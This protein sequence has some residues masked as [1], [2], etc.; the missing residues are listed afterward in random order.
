MDDQQPKIYLLPNLMTAGNL[1]CGFFAINKIILGGLHPEQ[2]VHNYKL[3]LLL[4]I[5]AFVFDFLDGR[6]ARMGGFESPFGIQFDSLADLVSFGLAPALL[7]V[8]IVLKDFGPVSW[9]IAFVYLVCG[10]LRLARFNCLAMQGHK[11]PTTDFVGFPIP[12]AAGV[13]A[14]L[15]LFMMWLNDSEKD[16]GRW[17][18]ALPALTLFLSYM[19]FSKFKYPSF[20]TIDWKTQF[21]LTKLLIV[22]VLL[23]L[24]GFFH[25]VMLAV[26]FLGYLLYGFFRPFISPRIRQEIEEGDDNEGS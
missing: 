2:A 22:I 10:A 15:T 4:I 12:A 8:N 21:S 3:S 14:S 26:I 13:I 25:Q 9:L 11:S 18:F 23:G 20:K 24:I 17:R 1:F 5:G 7:M 16:L 6:V 19:M